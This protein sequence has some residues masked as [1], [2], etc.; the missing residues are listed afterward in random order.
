MQAGREDPPD[1]CRWHRPEDNPFPCA[2][3][4]VLGF[5][6]PFGLALHPVTGALFAADNGGRGHD[7]LDLI[8]R[9]GNI[10]RITR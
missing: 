1:Q 5:P 4:F 8:R 10:L 3:T 2:P 9:E 6:N 7:E